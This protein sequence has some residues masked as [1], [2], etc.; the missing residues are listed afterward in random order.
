MAERRALRDGGLL[1]YDEHFFDR[2]EADRLF[3]VLR[4]D[5]PWRQET[6]RGRPFP[7]LTAWYADEG[8]TYSYSGVTHQ[9]E[10]WT[11]ELHEIKRRVESAAQA[12][13]N[14]LLLNRY[15]GGQDSIGYHA[16]D[17]PELGEN[18]VIASVSF[19]AV[20]DFHLK[21]RKSGDKLTLPL[22]HGSLLV[23]AGTCQHFWLHSVPKR[24]GEVGERINLTFRKILRAE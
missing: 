6:A 17:E 12:D 19:G 5:V 11:P 16:D 15:R 21:H 22:A 3:A 13:F 14:S 4:A 9:A 18:P 8:L 1:L 2:A 24:A 7:R 10:P 23:M 20:R